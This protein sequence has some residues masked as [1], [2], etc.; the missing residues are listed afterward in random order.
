MAGHVRKVGEN[1]YRLEYMLDGQ[2]YSKNVKS[3]TPRQADKLLVQFISEIE[4]GTYQGNVNTLFVDFAQTYLDN[5]ARQNCKPITVEGYIKMLNARI[6]NGIGTY[7]LSKITPIILNTFYNNLINDTKKNID[8]NGELKEVYLLGQESLNKYYNLIN[9]IFRYAVDMKIL[10]SNPNQSVPKPKTKKHE[11]NRRQFY[12]PDEL[13]KFITIVNTLN[14]IRFRLIFKLPVG[15]G[16]RKAEVLG[17]SKNDIDL[18]NCRLNINTSCEYMKKK[19]IYTD[20]KTNGS[21]RTIYYPDFLKNDLNEYLDT[22]TGNYLFEDIT[23]DQIDDK[24]DEVINISSLRRLTYH[25]LRHSH[26]TFLLANGADL[27]TVRNRLGHTDIST[28]NIYVHALEQND[29]KASK[30]INNFFK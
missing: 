2:K 1:R 15:C 17:I 4:N 9:G 21:Q 29:K 25:K 18:K 10:K 16:L 27:E 5:Y 20:L 6:L 26:A 13:K 7:R 8:E 12:D 22:F 24:L 3:S 28:T 30:K 23:P 11:I 14:D 19:K